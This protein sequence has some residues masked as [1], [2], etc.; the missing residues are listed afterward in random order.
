M[1]PV[2]FSSACGGPTKTQKAPELPEAPET[3][4][5]AEEASAA[6]PARPDSAVARGAARPASPGSKDPDVASPKPADT[7]TT[8]AKV[9]AEPPPATSPGPVCD[10]PARRAAGREHDRAR[11]SGAWDRRFEKLE[12][13]VTKSAL[14]ASMT[15]EQSARFLVRVSVDPCGRVVDAESTDASFMDDDLLACAVVSVLPTR[16]PPRKDDA[17]ERKTYE[18][19]VEAGDEGGAPTVRVQE[20]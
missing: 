12:S 20:R 13:C 5:V 16:F 3:T 6:P 18:V 14:V 1:A 10:A 8:G 17:L 11:R 4:L 9:A 2:A 7:P 19:Q 15:R